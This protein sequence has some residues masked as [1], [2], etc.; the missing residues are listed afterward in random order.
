MVIVLYFKDEIIRVFLTNFPFWNS[1]FEQKGFWAFVTSTRSLSL[2]K[3]IYYIKESWSI[4]NYMFGGSKYNILKVEIDPI[5]L[6]V[7]FG[8]AG[9]FLYLRFIKKF[10]I[11]YISNKLIKYL[12][13]SY[14]ILG[15]IYGAFLFNI[16]LMSVLYLSLVYC[17]TRYF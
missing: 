14:I 3:T 16:V 7:F 6:I 10:Y 13:V 11:D 17:E 1:L 12:A 8:F 9:S 15:M 2:E 5:D 4:T